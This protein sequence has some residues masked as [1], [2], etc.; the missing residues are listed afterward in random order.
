MTDKEK[1]IELLVKAIVRGVHRPNE[2]P[3]NRV[4]LDRDLYNQ[5][6]ALLKPAVCKTCK[7]FMYCT[8]ERKMTH[9]KKGECSDWQPVCE[10]CGD[11]G[12]VDW[13]SK[14]GVKQWINDE[15]GV[16]IANKYPCPKGCKPP[17]G[18]AEV[19]EMVEIEGMGECVAGCKI[20]GNNEMYHHK[21]CPYYSESLSQL[22][23]RLE[24]GL[25][26]Q[27]E[28]ITALQN[29]LLKEAK[30]NDRLEG[31]NKQKDELLFA[32]ESVRAP[33]NPLYAENKRLKE[34]IG[35]WAKSIDEAL[36]CIDAA[37]TAGL[38]IVLSQMQALGGTGD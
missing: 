3:F 33:I 2:K 12:E 38:I 18:Q 9:N 11:T 25:K 23:D 17:S 29:D 6:I 15:E 35:S 5:T 37:N 8:H 27:N 22:I 26:Q 19:G 36:G 30:R 20:Y 31:E 7:H 24:A 10:L 34:Q 28:D 21:D 14:E 13:G 1:A 4:E 32:Y 16:A